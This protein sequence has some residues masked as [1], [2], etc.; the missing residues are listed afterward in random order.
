MY[1][2]A[3]ATAVISLPYWNTGAG[4]HRD[5]TV[6]NEF[7]ANWSESGIVEGNPGANFNVSIRNNVVSPNPADYVDVNRSVGS[8]CA[9][10]NVFPATTD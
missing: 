10:L 3:D 8:Y 2:T 4:S 9:S 1:T 7:V 6:Q 5:V